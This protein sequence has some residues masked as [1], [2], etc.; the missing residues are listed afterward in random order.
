MCQAGFCKEVNMF[1]YG[2]IVGIFIGANLGLL[3]M[4]LLIASRDSKE[5]L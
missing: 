1:W 5:V 2:L 3:V 4:G